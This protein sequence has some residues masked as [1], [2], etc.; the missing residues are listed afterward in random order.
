LNLLGFASAVILAPSPPDAHI[1]CRSSFLHLS[2]P[3]VLLKPTAAMAS[4][5]PPTEDRSN[6]SAMPFRNANLTIEEACRRPGFAADARGESLAA[7]RSAAP[8]P[9]LDIPAYNWWNEGLHASPVPDTPLSSPRPSAMRQPGCAAAAEDRNGGFHGSSRQIHD[10]IRAASTIDYYGLTI[11]RPTSTSFAI[12]AGGAPETYGE[13]PFLTTGS[14]RICQRHSSDDANTSVPL[15]LPNTTPYTADRR[16][17]AIK[18]TS[19][20][21]ITTYGHLLPAFRAAITEAKPTRS[22]AT[23]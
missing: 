22:C 3:S 16:R 8:I 18:W 19:T 21:A 6:A 4:T 23:H 13:D 12:H 15:R 14:C 7:Y 5:T 20:P 11:C 17:L 10:A 9:R 2:F 1:V